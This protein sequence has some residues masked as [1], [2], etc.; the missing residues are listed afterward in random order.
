M[1]WAS[2][3]SIEAGSDLR[4]LYLPLNNGTR[5]SMGSKSSQSKDEKT[6]NRHSAGKQRNGLSSLSLMI[7]GVEGE[8]NGLYVGVPQDKHSKNNRPE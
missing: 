3:K 1:L 2:Q 5:F 8:A 7:S 4:F 6:V